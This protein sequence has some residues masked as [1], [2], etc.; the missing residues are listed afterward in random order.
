MPARSGT[1]VGALYDSVSPNTG[2]RAI[3]IAVGQELARHGV[4]TTQVLSPFEEVDTRGRLVVVGG[5]D[6][7]RPLGD[8]FYDRFRASGPAVLNSAGVW[9]DADQLEYLRDYEFVSA[10]TSREVDVLRSAVP[11]AQLLPCTTTT[12]ES[13]D[14]R[15]EGL[16]DDE[17]AVG[18]HVV[19]HT[20]RLVPELVEIVD[21][22]DRPKVFIP[23]THYNYD[24]S[25]MESLPFDRSRA[26]VLPR[27]DP[28]ELHAVMRQ[29]SYV[30][31]ST[32][33]GTIFSYSQNVPFITA[34][35]RKVRNYLDDRGLS[36]RIFHDG[37]SLK[38][39]VRQTEEERPDFSAQIAADRNAVH[40]AFARVAALAG[41]QKERTDEGG[42]GQATA[43]NGAAEPKLLP[44]AEDPL[45]VRT[46]LLQQQEAVVRDRD[47]ALAEAHR[48]TGDLT[49]QVR[50]LGAEQR[51]L[52][53]EL[54]AGAEHTARLQA[55]LDNALALLDGTL[56]RRFRAAARTVVDR[57]RSILVRQ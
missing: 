15:I 47:V 43:T 45:T 28:L 1:D 35:Q 42:E 38:D 54:A 39:L 41:G 53:A 7:I 9:D 57:I 10:R 40:E 50:A 26:V 2:D 23:F 18:I 37:A 51:V 8:P 24:D 12:L 32:L 20:L 13:P 30:V 52:R 55:D 33:H 22:I 3:G 6:L 14:F 27:L 46:F 4:G 17:P 31:V 56:D 19:P 48:R 16:P 44:A 11:D 5:G 34:D 49:A 21:A 36:E 29:M 25:F